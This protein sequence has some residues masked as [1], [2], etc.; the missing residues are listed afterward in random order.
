MVRKAPQGIR[1]RKGRLGIFPA[2]FN[3][4]TNAHVALVRK[5]LT[6]GDLNEILVLLDAQAMDKEI[7]GAPLEGR[8]IMLKRLFQRDPK[9]S[10][11][12][13]NRGLF[14]EKVMPL[15]ILYPSADLFFI[16]GFD[17]ILRVMDKKY[18]RNC[19]KT[20]S[21]LFS[22]CQFMVANREN[23]ET[24]AFESL[25]CNR[26]NKRYRERVSFFTLPRKYSFLSSS[27]IRERIAKGKGVHGLV[28]ASVLALIKQKGL[29]RRKS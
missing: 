29:Y 12:I 28:P 8:L 21:E 18:Y 24:G 22:Q 9:V 27:L 13:S 4:P 1:R 19:S 15:R 3:P 23:Q 2:S 11:G 20:L 26:T 17:T 7:T 5:A 14:V 10:I 16:V 6:K 25:F